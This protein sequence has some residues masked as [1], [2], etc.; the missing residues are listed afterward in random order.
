[1]CKSLRFGGW[2]VICLSDTRLKFAKSREQGQLFS[3]SVVVM[4]M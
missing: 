3:V 1:M 4:E 2:K